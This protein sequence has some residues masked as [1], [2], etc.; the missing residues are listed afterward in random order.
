MHTRI[1][2][3]LILLSTFQSCVSYGNGCNYRLLESTISR[4]VKGIFDDA[5]RK[6]GCHGYSNLDCKSG[7]KSFE[8]SLSKKIHVPNGSPCQEHLLQRGLAHK[9]TKVL[10]K[11]KGKFGCMVSSVTCSMQLD[12][13]TQCNVFGSGDADKQ[14]SG[15]SSY[16]I[17]GNNYNKC[18]LALLEQ[19]VVNEIRGTL[20]KSQ[21]RYKCPKVDIVRCNKQ[22]GTFHMNCEVFVPTESDIPSSTCDMNFVTQE[23]SEDIGESFVRSEMKYGCDLP[24]TLNCNV[25]GAEFPDS[26][27]CNI[28]TPS[29]QAAEG[30]STS[31]SEDIPYQSERRNENQEGPSSEQ[32]SNNFDNSDHTGE[33]MHSSNENHEEEANED[34]MRSKKRKTATP[35]SDSTTQGKMHDE[36]IRKNYQKF[37]GRYNLRGKKS[38]M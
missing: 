15:K 25:Y 18:N 20:T 27:A 28:L 23:L 31:T 37:F 12:G 13:R 26:V 21:I 33:N 22:K 7:S 38:E 14:R 5:H 34:G 30:S 6:Y 17:Y 3:T 29:E 24:E 19:D 36:K 9:I 2:L 11:S 10:R 32:E 35:N 16:N 4:K 1:F 8:C